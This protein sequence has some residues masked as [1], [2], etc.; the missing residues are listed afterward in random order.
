MRESRQRCEDDEQNCQLRAPADTEKPRSQPDQNGGSFAWPPPAP[1][2]LCYLRVSAATAM[3]LLSVACAMRASRAICYAS[4]RGDMSRLSRSWTRV[5]R[6]TATVR[7]HS[8]RDE[9]R[10]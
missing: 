8:G 5:T 6:S 4:R 7:N 10:L 1:T 3:G 9:M 2:T